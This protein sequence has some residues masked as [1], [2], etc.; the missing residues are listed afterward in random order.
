MKISKAD[1]R[2]THV[3]LLRTNG[4]QK[5][6]VKIVK[7]ACKT[8]DMAGREQS[9]ERALHVQEG[10]HSPSRLPCP[11]RDQFAHTPY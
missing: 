5:E 9:I 2:Q 8:T 6:E 10:T 11:F 7:D 3:G 1:A 4:V